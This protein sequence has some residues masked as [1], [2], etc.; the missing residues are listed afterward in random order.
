MAYK[1]VRAVSSGLRDRFNVFDKA[2]VVRWPLLHYSRLHLLAPVGLLLITLALIVGTV[3]PQD[4]EAENADGL[5][6]DLSLRRSYLSEVENFHEYY[7]TLPRDQRV[8]AEQRAN[9]EASDENVKAIL[10]RAGLRGCSNSIIPGVERR[11][12]GKDVAS[13][14]LMVWVVT[15]LVGC[16]LGLVLW[17]Y[18][19]VRDV[20][21]LPFSSERLWYTPVY[22]LCISFIL[23]TPV[24]I[25]VAYYRRAAAYVIPP[26]GWIFDSRGRLF[27]AL[28]VLQLASVAI[29]L[30][31]S[32][33]PSAF[34]ALV[35][36]LFVSLLY[37]VWMSTTSDILRVAIIEVGLFSAIVVVLANARS[38]AWIVRVVYASSKFLA[39]GW[40]VLFCNVA[41]W[42][43]GLVN[44]RPSTISIVLGYGLCIA[45]VWRSRS[46]EIKLRARQ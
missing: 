16:T 41:L 30:L 11:C 42:R 1:V 33:L 27:C 2:V 26:S 40:L 29:G 7:S 28:L 23:A 18:A 10:S 43:L 14:R 24:A 12:D 4:R 34:R 46:A 6:A 5:I 21:M 13:G 32:R 38:L 19:Q 20:W 22:A 35:A 37:A 39:L 8:T 45:H 17:M 31:Q 15:T 9:L 44:G 25:V 3:L 36:S